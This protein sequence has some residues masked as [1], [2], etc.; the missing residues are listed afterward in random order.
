MRKIVI[1]SFQKNAKKEFMWKKDSRVAVLFEHSGYWMEGMEWYMQELSIF[2][3][4]YYGEGK[5]HWQK[6]KEEL[7]RWN[8]EGIV[9]IGS[10]ETLQKACWLRNT[11]TDGNVPVILFSGKDRWQLLDKENLWIRKPDGSTVYWGYQKRNE[12]DLLVLPDAIFQK[13][14]IQTGW[15]ALETA[16]KPWQ[17][18]MNQLLAEAAGMELMESTRT[19]LE[20]LAEPMRICYGIPME[21]GTYF[22]IMY[23]YRQL[24]EEQKRKLCTWCKVKIAEGCWQLEKKAHELCFRELSGVI[25]PERDVFILTQMAMEGIENLPKEQQLS[26]QQVEQFYG[27]LC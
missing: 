19:L 1:S 11:L 21:I 12:K 20:E 7:Y 14:K 26:W 17:K 4:V 3:E 9:G 2:C 22:A 16:M 15:E 23:L 8:P 5:K 13:K 6:K 18:G 27:E 24:S 25:L 10:F